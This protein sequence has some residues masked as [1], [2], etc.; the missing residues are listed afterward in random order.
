MV[1]FPMHDSIELSDFISF[2]RDEESGYCD[3]VYRAILGNFTQI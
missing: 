3:G 1:V 2:R